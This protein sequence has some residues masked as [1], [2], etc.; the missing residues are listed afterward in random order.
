MDFKIKGNSKYQIKI[1]GN[2]VIKSS[3]INDG[4]LKKSA[5]KQ[6]EF[7][8]NFFKTPKI[9]EITDISFSM[10]YIHGDSFADFFAL[11]TKNDLDNLIYKI[12]GYLKERIIGQF[13]MPFSLVEEKLKMIPEATEFL[14]NIKNI[15]YIPINVGIC[16][17]DFTL[18]NM[19]FSNDIYLIDFLDSYIDSP[20]IDVLKLRQ[21]TDLL[22]SFN[23]VEKVQDI[24]KVKIGLDYIDEWVRSNYNIQHYNLLQCVNLFRIYPYTTNDKIR[25]FL[26][27]N[28]NQLCEHL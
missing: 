8:S 1:E 15:D 17:G 3:L 25:D 24:V 4:R 19:V 16:H 21:D 9:H 20:T 28:I 2:K 18:S 12:D 11:A 7:K 6:L 26:K 22:W 10:D 27:R 5:Q 14:N 13:D 23:M